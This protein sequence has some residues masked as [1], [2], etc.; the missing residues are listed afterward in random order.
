MAED[1]INSAST[2][3]S[4]SFLLGFILFIATLAHSSLLPL[5]CL[6]PPH[7]ARVSLSMESAVYNSTT[8]AITVDLTAASHA[9]PLLSYGEALYWWA[10][11]PFIVFESVF[12]GLS[13]LFALFDFYLAPSTLASHKLQPN[14]LPAQTK[15]DVAAY[16]Q[17]LVTSII[18]HCFGSIPSLALFALIARQ[19][20]L[21]LSA[22]IVSWPVLLYQI[23][24]LLVV[25]EVLFYYIHRLLH[26]PLFFRS[27]HSVHHSFTAPVAVSATHCHILEHVACNLFPMLAG[28]LLARANWYLYMGWCGLA[29]VNTVC[30]HSGYGWWV[31]CAD[32]HDRHHST[33]KCAFGTLGVLDWLH[34][35]RYQDLANARK[36][37]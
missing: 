17:A 2:A 30:V 1:G 22:H 23:A 31:L 8:S 36:A 7:S 14:R 37:L 20:R 32:N 5:F 28:T 3:H 6:S 26:H 10:A 4:H 11:Y 35:T 24:I 12:F 27:I 19:L 15:A 33:N 13:L 34:R 21:P 29:V 25:E 9:S 18:N 16:K